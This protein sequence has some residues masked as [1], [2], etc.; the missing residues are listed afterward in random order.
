[1][2]RK[3]VLIFFSIFLISAFLRLYNIS[4][5]PPGVNR[6]EAS[7]GYTAYS[8]LHTGKDEYGRFLPFSF[9]SFG[10]WKLPFYIYSVVP[11]VKA[12]GLNSLAVRLPSAILGISSVVLIFFFIRLLFRNN[13]LSLLTMFLVAISPWHIHLSR[14]ESES[15][16][17]VFM[18]IVATVLFLLSLKK[19]RWLIIP[20]AFFF[21]LTYFTYAGNHIFTTLLILG[22]A[23]I[24]RPSLKIEKYTIAAVI[25]FGVMTGTIFYHTLL[26]ADAT[27]LSGISIFGDPS[28]VHTK[29]EIPRNEHENPQS[30]LSKI[31]H[32]KATFALER[33]GQNYLNSFSAEFLFIKG[34]ENKA[35]NIINFGNVY[36][37]EAPFL[38]F[39]LIYL[40]V[41]KK[42]KEKKLILLWLFIA[43][44]ATSITKDAPHTNRIFAIFPI[45]PF[46]V[47]CGIYWMFKDGIK[48]NLGKVF[49]LA[50]I[51]L[52]TLNFA[53][54]ID[55]YYVHFPRN[56]GQSWGTGYEKLV[57]Y[58]ST[59]NNRPGKVVISR[60]QYSPY[61][62]LLFYGKYD[63]ASYQ[64]MV[65]RYPPTK[66]Q[67]VHVKSF[68][69]YE[70]REI[71]WVE[72]VKLPNTLLV[73]WTENIPESVRVNAIKNEIFLSSGES[74][75]T[76]V[77]TK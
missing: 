60:Q 25:V 34:G 72:D 51:L 42:G 49:A 62:Y 58:L 35:H 37:I 63:P 20:S 75:L 77:K 29:I 53:L 13:T 70:F 21:A 76:I 46:I 15:N 43:P 65:V 33:V 31:L 61:I 56:E 17:A 23:F 55:R 41:F 18:I 52:F 39:G 16:A 59:E 9:E 22:L 48:E 2:S 38:L 26:G 66:D 73:D 5:I 28:I 10:D 1:M 7:I 50:L 11:F 8:L 45:L 14:V 24:Y 32:N 74:M 3:L 47:A 12:L 57:E 4:E 64:R 67:F 30:F 40:V 6:D 68:D 71:N 36:L 19:K 27:K 44:I 54:Y 69:R